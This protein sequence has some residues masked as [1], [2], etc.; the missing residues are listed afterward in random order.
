MGRNARLRKLRREARHELQAHPQMAAWAKSVEKKHGGPVVAYKHAAEKMSKV[1]QDFA[2]PLMEGVD[3]MEGTRNALL[4]AMTVW[5][6]SLL[7]AAERAKPE[8]P[9]A[10]LLAQP[11]IKEVFELLL[12]RKQE[13]YPNNRR[14]ILDYQLVPAGDGF[15]FN[16]ISSLG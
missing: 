12:A 7:D 16:V 15:R 2:E 10:L 3:S 4:F 8:G 6:Y 9:A 13:L 5:N 14:A 11:Q 1:I